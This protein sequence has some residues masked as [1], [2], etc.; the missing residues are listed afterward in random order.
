[1]WE[2]LGTI[3][4][5]QM[6]RSV[7]SRTPGLRFS[8]RS[9]A[10][11]V[12]PPPTLPLGPPQTLAQIILPSQM[13]PQAPLSTPPQMLPLNLSTGSTDLQESGS[14]QLRARLLKMQ[15]VA[16]CWEQASSS[17]VRRRNYRIRA[18]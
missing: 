18:F 16:S 11:S 5:G 2:R 13:P 6:P 9:G 12:H 8:T 17:L 14:Q 7:V 1:M 4:G 15:K 10:G 3:R